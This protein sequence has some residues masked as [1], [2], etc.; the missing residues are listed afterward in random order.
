MI[1]SIRAGLYC[2]L[3]PELL[4]LTSMTKNLLSR[5]SETTATAIADN[6]PTETPPK[7]EPLKH[8]LIG[9]PKSVKQTIAVLHVLGYA[10]AGSWSPLM[11]TANAGEVMSILVRCVLRE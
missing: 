3:S 1:A 6:T 7:R 4:K 11:P 8:L 10:E 5:P 9:S 2:V